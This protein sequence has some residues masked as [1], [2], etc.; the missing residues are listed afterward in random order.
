MTPT[1]DDVPAAPDDAPEA[2]PTEEAPPHVA[3]IKVTD[4]N[5]NIRVQLAPKGIPDLEIPTF[6]RLAAKEAERLILG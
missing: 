2:P 6:L 1:L 4:E 3:V 5:G